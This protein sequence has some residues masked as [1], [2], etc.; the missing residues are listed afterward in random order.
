MV[1]SESSWP[2][3]VKMK[4]IGGQKGLGFEI[5]SGSTAKGDSVKK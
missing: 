3:G 4:E 5:H 2:K 1:D